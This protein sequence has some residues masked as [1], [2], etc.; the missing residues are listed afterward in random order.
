[1]GSTIHPG[2]ERLQSARHGEGSQ[3]APST[4]Q[5]S[6]RQGKLNSRIQALLLTARSSCALTFDHSASFARIQGDAGGGQAKNHE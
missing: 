2:Q 6:S 1:M 4:D 3:P 5:C